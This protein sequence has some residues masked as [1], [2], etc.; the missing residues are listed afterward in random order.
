MT[1]AHALE[2]APVGPQA[3]PQRAFAETTADVAIYGGALGGGKTWALLYEGAKLTAIPW[4]RGVRGVLFRRQEIDLTKGGGLWDASRRIFPAFGGR[5][6]ASDLDWA[7]EA[8]TRAIEHVHRIELRHLQGE[9]THEAFSGTEYDLVAFDELQTFTERQFR[10]MLTRLRSTSGVE[11]RFRATCNPAPDSWL[12]RE[13][14]SGEAAG[15]LS[16][17]I[18]PDGYAIPERSGVLRWIGVADVDGDDGLSTFG[19]REEAIEATGAEPLSIT[20]VLSRGLADNP[21]LLAADPRYAARVGLASRGDRLR[22]VGD[23]DHEGRARGGCWLAREGAG[24]FFDREHFRIADEPPSPIVRTV[25]AWDRAASVPTAKRPDPDATEGVRISVCRGGEI[26]IDDLVHDQ[27][28]PVA[29]LEFMLRTAK[30]DGPL[31][32][33]ALFQDVGGAGKSD[34]EIAAAML[35]GYTTKIVPSWGADPM[36]AASDR[37]ASRA[38]RTNAKRWAPLVERGQVFLRRASWN[39]RLRAQAHAFPFGKHDDAIDA[40]SCGIVALEIGATT[41]AEAMEAAIRE[42][43]SHR[44]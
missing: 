25:R 23:R 34:A 2:P 26:W 27:A 21:A 1:A 11:P 42:R 4:A 16:W 40:V 8:S 19:T 38:K 33:V 12:H 5:A 24:A 41:L 15:L 39:G 32:T 31:V 17:W 3:G 13:T 30:A 43:R 35:R 37:G 36:E 28:G 18:G 9:D 22:L 6:R 29:A 14:E 44:R 20:F 10:Y 7:F